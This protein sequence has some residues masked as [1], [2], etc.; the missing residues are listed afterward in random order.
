MTEWNRSTTVVTTGHCFFRCVAYIHS[1]WRWS[2]LSCSLLTGWQT[3]SCTCWTLQPEI[4]SKVSVLMVGDLWELLHTTVGDNQQVILKRLSAT[5]ELGSPHQTLLVVTCESQED[6]D[7]VLD[8]VLA[9]S[10]SAFDKEDI[11][12]KLA[13]FS[14]L[15]LPWARAPK[16]I[17]R[18]WR[19]DVHFNNIFPLSIQT[20]SLQ[21]QRYT[22]NKAFSRTTTFFSVHAFHDQSPKFAF[23]VRIWTKVYEEVE[24]KI[25]IGVVKVCSLWNNCMVDSINCTLLH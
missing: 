12:W 1:E 7:E 13:T 3:G 14:L 16:N 9:L 24:V 5:H 15:C 17:F 19:A 11:K 10:L 8:V 4:Y 21:T 22:V 18:S 2:L 25:V 23:L 6:I 20:K